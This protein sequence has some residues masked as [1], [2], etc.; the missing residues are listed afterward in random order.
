MS[1]AAGG[2]PNHVVSA[3]WSPRGSVSHPGHVSVGPN[4]HGSGSRDRAKYRKLPDTN[5]SG[6][7]QLN[8]VRPWSGVAA[9]GLI[10]VEEHRLGIV[11]QG[12]Y[13]QRALGGQ[14]GLAGPAG[15]R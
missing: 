2:G 4:Q 7:D 15:A 10:E 1:Y 12:E 3:S 14:G 11:Q 9:A 13:P 5:V 8:P 6:V